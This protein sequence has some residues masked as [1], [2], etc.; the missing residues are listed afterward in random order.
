MIHSFREICS[1]PLLSRWKS[2][3]AQDRKQQ[4]FHEEHKS[5]EAQKE[6]EDQ[7][8]QAHQEK[9]K[10]D[11]RHGYFEQMAV[12][13][14]DFWNKKIDR[15]TEFSKLIAKLCVVIS[16]TLV[17]VYIRGLHHPAGIAL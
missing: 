17:A 11:Q 12:E 5:Q 13:C 6:E 14:V 10:K 3:S 8:E 2:V 1:T 16:Q 9:S 4:Q 7:P 15:D